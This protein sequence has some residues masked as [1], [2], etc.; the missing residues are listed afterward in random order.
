MEATMNTERDKFLTEILGECWHGSTIVGYRNN[1]SSTQ[2]LCKCGQGSLWK[3]CFD[4]DDY[5]FKQNNFSTWECFGKL[6]NLLSHH[7]RR[8]EFF[9]TYGAII[10]DHQRPKYY[11]EDRYIDPDALANIAYEFLK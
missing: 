6:L 2:A 3:C 5:Q 10:P 8:D 7:E 1:P 9:S 4:D 11:L